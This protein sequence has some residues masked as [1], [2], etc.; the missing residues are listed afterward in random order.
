M[1][2]WLCNVKI[3]Q[4]QS[5]EDLRKQIHAHHIEDVLIWNRL[6]LSGHFNQQEETSWTKKIMSFGVEGPTCSGRPKSRQ[7]M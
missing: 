4:K 6:R 7:K 1:I 5:T 3:E 2:C